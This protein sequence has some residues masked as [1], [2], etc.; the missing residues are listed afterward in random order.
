MDALEILRLNPVPCD[1]LVRLKPQDN[2]ANQ[3]L[4][5]HRVFVRPLGDGLFVRPLEQ[6]IQL[7]TGRLLDERDQILDPHRLRRADGH[8]DLTALIV[9]AVLADGLGARAKRRDRYAQRHDKI[10]LRSGGVGLET[11]VVIHQPLAPGDRCLLRYEIG[12]F[13]LEV[14]VVGI[15]TLLHTGDQIGDI[16]DV[17]HLPVRVEHLDK[18]A[19]VRAL[20]L[21]RQ[22]D[23]HADGGDGVLHRMSTV[24]HLNGEPQPTYPDLVDRQ[25]TGVPSVLFVVKR[26]IPG[27]CC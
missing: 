9:C 18:P 1:V 27:D 26:G 10:N 17:D 7:A 22:I 4:D 13:N 23:E 6:R 19:H 15:E 8:R 24:A 21:H 16:L 5:K 25:F 3:I 2:V 12:K 14:R 11:H 20:K